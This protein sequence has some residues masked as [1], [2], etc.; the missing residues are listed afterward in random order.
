MVAKRDGTADN[1]LAATRAL[2]PTC[3]RV[4]EAETIERDGQVWLVRTCA[5]HGRAESLV[6]GDAD[7][8][9]WSRKFLRPGRAPAVAV[10]ER[11]HGCPYDCGFVPITSSTRV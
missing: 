10:T 5:D 3:L 8:W 7:W 2:C 1:V 11:E 9:R 4:V 6:L